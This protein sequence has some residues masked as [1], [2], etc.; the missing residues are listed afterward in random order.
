MDADL[1][2]APAPEAPVAE[3]PAV[4]LVAAFANAQPHQPNAPFAPVAE[5]PVEAPVEAV[6]PAAVEPIAAVEAPVAPAEVAFDYAGWLK[7]QELPEDVAAIKTA[8]QSGA[9]AQA[10]QRT[11]QD[12]AFGKLLADPH[13]ASAYLKLQTTDFTALSDRELHAAAF[14]HAHPELKPEVAAIKARREFEAEY[15]A[16]EFDDAD[17]PQVQEAK[18][19]SANMR[20]DALA[21]MEG[22]KTAS[23]ESVLTAATPTADGPTP[24]QVQA[25]EARAAHWVQG[26]AGI[27]NAPSLELE[28]QVDGQ[29]LKLAFDHKDPAFNAALLDP[30][31]WFF[32]Q[33]CPGGDASKPNFDRLAEMYALTMQPDVLLKNAI[34]H[35]KAQIGAHIPMNVAVNPAPNAP[36]TPT[37]FDG[38][39]DN[40][41]A[42]ALRSEMARIQQATYN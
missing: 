23:R 31:K 7:S 4:D 21:T 25:E 28:Y 20:T 9:T 5:P 36:Q 19:L 16:A 41:V 26:V 38:T 29:A 10:N 17:D 22:A 39:H 24:A 8:L 42:A 37:A 14:A 35:G 40:R 27:V 3:S 34:A 1:E 12:V 30:N 2:V 33:I 18:V 15:A 13:A 6:A 32:E 11:A